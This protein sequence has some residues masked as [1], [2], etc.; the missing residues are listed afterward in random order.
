[1]LIVLNLSVNRIKLGKMLVAPWRN[2]CRTCYVARQ[3]LRNQHITNVSSVSYSRHH[4]S[5]SKQQT[6]PLLLR[7]STGPKVLVGGSTS[8]SRASLCQTAAIAVPADKSSPEPEQDMA[9]QQLQDAK[10][11]FTA[12]ENLGNT[13]SFF[14]SI[15]VC[16]FFTV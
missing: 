13:V 6:L 9:F 12:P 11:K 14:Y 10:N 3:S 4:N 1:M 2:V 7:V 8:V 15:V 5:G 16:Y